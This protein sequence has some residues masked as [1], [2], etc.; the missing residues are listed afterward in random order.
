MERAFYIGGGFLVYDLVVMMKKN[1]YFFE[2]YSR[3]QQWADR[4]KQIIKIR[5]R[6]IDY[7]I[8]SHCVVVFV[9]LIFLTLILRIMT[10][11]TMVQTTQK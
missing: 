6:R 10:V 4:R 8:A 5:M 1:F 9:Y 7:N 3:R 11:L 2:S